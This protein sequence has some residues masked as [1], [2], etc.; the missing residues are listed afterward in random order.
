MGAVNTMSA[1]AAQGAAGRAASQKP[2][3]PVPPGNQAAILCGVPL[4]HVTG[5]HSIFLGSFFAGRKVVLMKK[6][7]AGKALE[8]IQREKPTVFTGV[9]T[10]SYELMNHPDFEKFDTSSLGSIGGGGAAFKS[11]FAGEIKGKFKKGRA[12][13]GWGMTETNAVSTL[14]S[15]DGYLKK[16]DSCGRPVMNVEVC[17]ITTDEKLDRLGV[18]EV[19]ELCIR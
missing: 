11:S 13:Q 8:L 9:P 12:T 19:G 4:F 16:P 6:W 3:Q 10:M 14:N 1:M 7:D 18:N 15:G 2:G 5:L 17:A